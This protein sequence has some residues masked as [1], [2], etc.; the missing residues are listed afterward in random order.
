MQAILEHMVR[1]LRPK[2][3]FEEAVEATLEA[4]IALHG[5]EYGNLQLLVRDHLVIVAQRGL[6]PAFLHTFARVGEDDGSAC[7]RALKLGT[8]VVISNVELDP[9]FARFRRDAAIAGFSAVQS[10]PLRTTKGMP[11]G[12]VSTHFVQVHTPSPI[13]MQTLKEFAQVAADHLCRVLNG[14]SIESCAQR[15]NEKLYAGLFSANM[16]PAFRLDEEE[17]KQ[18]T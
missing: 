4:A 1:R 12:V 17:P 18:S 15:M 14:E 11:L 9:D 16:S 5:A 8:P 13:E 7:G 10:T 6:S 2:R 3:D